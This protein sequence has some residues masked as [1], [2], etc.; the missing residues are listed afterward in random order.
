MKTKQRIKN[1]WVKKEFFDWIVSGEKTLEM[2]VL[3][4]VFESI[5]KGDFIKLNNQVLIRVYEREK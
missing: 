1:L 4:P 3:F 2:R 5:K